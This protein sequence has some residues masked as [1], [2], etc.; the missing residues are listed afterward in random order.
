MTKICEKCHKR[1]CK[2]GEGE[3]FYLFRGQEFFLDDEP[4]EEDEDTPK[5]IEDLIDEDFEDDDFDI[6]DFNTGDFD[7]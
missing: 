3:D 7:D 2:C 5:D 4:G 1:P 6:D